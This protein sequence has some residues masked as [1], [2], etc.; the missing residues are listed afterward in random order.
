MRLGRF[1]SIHQIFRSRHTLLVSVFSISVALDQASKF[2]VQKYLIFGSSIPTDGI[3]RLT[4]VTNSGGAFGL[5][6]NQTFALTIASFI[7]IFIILFLY[8][9]HYPTKRK[10]TH[11][12]LG[13]LLGGATGNLI[14][15][16]MWKEV[17]DFIDVGIWPVFNFADSSIVVGFSIFTVL[18]LFSGKSQQGVILAL[19]SPSTTESDGAQNLPIE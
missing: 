6:P 7:G 19:P 1:L 16:L 11:L 5:F 12:S 8:R 4:F 9:T 17:V 18:Y 14:D 3:F 2:L 13:L 10:L 15:R